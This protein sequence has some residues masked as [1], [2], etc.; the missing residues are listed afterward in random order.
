LHNVAFYDD[1]IKT[2]YCVEGLTM[3]QVSEVLNIAVGKVYNRLKY[4]GIPSRSQG[5]YEPTA[6]ARECGRKQGLKMK[7]RKVSEETKAKI[8]YSHFKGGIGAKKQRGDGYI[9]IYFP[10]HPKANKEGLIM[11]HR[12]VMECYLGRWLD[13]DECVHHINHKRDDNRLCNLRLMT[14]SEHMSMHMRERYSKSEN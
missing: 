3:K 8:S 4:M 9:A 5:D 12:L 10:E 7:G 11:E 6:K 14:K 1:E 13:D 2:L